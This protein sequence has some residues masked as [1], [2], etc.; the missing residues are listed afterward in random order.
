MLE[1]YVESLESA[2][3]RTITYLYWNWE[4]DQNGSSVRSQEK[5]QIKRA[6]ISS[7]TMYE[8]TTN[9]WLQSSEK[10]PWNLEMPKHL[11]TY[12]KCSRDWKKDC[13]KTKRTGCTYTCCH[14]FYVSF[15]H[16]RNRNSIVLSIFFFSL[17][18]G[19]IVP[20]EVEEAIRIGEMESVSLSKTCHKAIFKSKY[21][22]Q[23]S[24]NKWRFGR[25][26]WK[27]LFFLLKS[28]SINFFYD[29]ILFWL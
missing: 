18:G 10:R 3:T 4:N 21:T 9:T 17:K 6:L 29:L 22:L 13:Q 19:L 14:P 25:L 12:K 26:I 24:N 2:W 8:T 11:K 1:D 20:A 16:F 23:K 28:T 7:F 15:F 5:T 27:Y